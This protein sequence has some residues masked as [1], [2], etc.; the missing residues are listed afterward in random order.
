MRD[1]YLLHMRP[2]ES[3]FVCA[4]GLSPIKMPFTDIPFKLYVLEHDVISANH[5]PS[6]N[7]DGLYA[8]FSG[9]N[10]YSVPAV[11][12]PN[13][14]FTVN[15]KPTDVSKTT[16]NIMFPDVTYYS[17][18][19]NGQ[20]MNYSQNV[21]GLY[22]LQYAGRFFVMQK[23][24]IIYTMAYSVANWNVTT[25]TDVQKTGVMYVPPKY[26]ELVTA[27]VYRDEAYFFAEHGVLKLK[28]GG[29]VLNTKTM[30]YPH[31]C[32][33]ILKDSCQIVDDKIYFLT[34]MGLWRFDGSRFERV[35]S[36]CLDL[37]D[38]SAGVETGMMYG[39]Y[40]AHVALRDGNRRIVVYDP[41]FDRDRFL[42]EEVVSF[43]AKYKGYV[44]RND[45]IYEMTE[46]GL[47]P[48]GDPCSLCCT[49]MLGDRREP[50]TEWVRIE[51]E[52]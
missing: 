49:F 22:G 43:G 7:I 13:C 25:N 38:F 6:R 18:G 28:M 12:L 14:I 5:V 51:G 3:G 44:I 33:V 9:K 34:T 26:G 11:S 45:L 23:D 27:I 19:L 50:C 40:Y 32:G 30:M 20:M 46:R 10:F 41:Y 24:R 4:E 36:P 48:D 8:V 37:A 17:M 52:G 16:W 15:M 35:A 1:V 39:Q 29:K 2:T 42:R 31:N 21:G 47:P